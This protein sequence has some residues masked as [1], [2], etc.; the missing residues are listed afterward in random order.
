MTIR[1]ELTNCEATLLRDIAEPTA[2]RRYVAETYA[3]AIRSSYHPT[4][5]W[6]K[7][8]RAIIE[9]WSLSALNWIKREAWKRVEHAR[10]FRAGL[11]E[12]E[13]AAG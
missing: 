4:V 5:D 7:V 9:R 10:A 12:T 11:E 8:N 13:R 1:M 3:L 6:G 2:T